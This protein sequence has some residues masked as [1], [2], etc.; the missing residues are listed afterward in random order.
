MRAYFIFFVALCSLPLFAQRH[1]LTVNGD[2]PEGQLLLMIGQEAEGAPRRTA[3]MESFVEKHPKHDSAAW[4]IQ[5][6]QTVYMKASE[7]DK[8]LQAGEK[9]L[10]ADP[11]DLLCQVDS[12][13]APDLVSGLLQMIL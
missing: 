10:A 2:T 6:L 8:A 3:M 9:P 11:M 1:K 7:F 5:Q 4:V 13:T 12:Q